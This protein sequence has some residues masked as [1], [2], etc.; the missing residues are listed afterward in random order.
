MT[1]G[2]MQLV[3]YGAQ[4]TYLTGNPQITFFKIVYRRHTN[5]S[6]ETIR[7]T[8]N[9]DTRTDTTKE[10]KGSVIVSRNGDLLSKIYVTSSSVGITNGLEIVKD[11]SIDIGGQEI[12]KQTK[13]WIQIWNELTIKEDKRLGY[14]NMIGCLN[15]NINTTGSIGVNHVQIPL[16]FWFC[17][18][19]GLALPLISLQYHEVQLNFTFGTSVGVNAEIN[20]ECD[21]FY[22]DTDERR[23]FAQVSH[24]YLIEQVQVQK[25]NNVSDHKIS[26]NHPVKEI[27]WTSSTD[28]IDAS[29]SLNGH[30]RFEKQKKEYFQLRQ[31]YDYHS[32][33]PGYNIPITEKTELLTTPIDT[34][35]TKHNVEPSILNDSGGLGKIVKLSVTQIDFGTTHTT[36]FQKFKIGDMISIVIS[37]YPEGTRT[38]GDGVNPSGGDAGNIETDITS[39]KTS[40]HNVTA[41]DTVNNKITFEPQIQGK[42]G[43]N[44]LINNLTINSELGDHLHVFIIGRIQQKE[45]RCS[46]LEKN[47]NVYSFS[48]RPEDHQPSGTC[49]FS[50]IDTARLITGANL[51]SG[52]NIYAVN[53][54]ILRIMSGMGGVAYSN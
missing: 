45:S 34:G 19:P 22:L 49:N 12:D 36:A 18:N 38:L 40:F 14:K 51:A 16:L 9:G 37:A 24:E 2:L 21:Y 13:E 33:I 28:Y 39:S 27:I 15:N 48:L 52:D 30:E 25:L 46:K 8:I 17:R 50:R 31:P 1:G 43:L 29:L 3:A 20:V 23:R 5:F 4:D 35:I 41:I 10:N 6:M 54:N 32:A 42:N 7:Q 53:Y 11:V 26:F 44:N 47:I